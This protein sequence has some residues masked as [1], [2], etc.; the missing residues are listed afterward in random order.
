MSGVSVR[1][2]NSGEIL[3]IESAV[4][5]RDNTKKKTYLDLNFTDA[6]WVESAT[7][8]EEP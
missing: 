5:S 7:T 3:A 1:N 6:G 4:I 8:A 2:E